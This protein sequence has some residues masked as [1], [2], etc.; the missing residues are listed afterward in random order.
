[1][2][3]SDWS[4]LVSATT[5]PGGALTTPTDLRLISV[6]PF[7][8]RIAWEDRSEGETFFE[9]E[10]SQS[11]VFT[12][13]TITFMVVSG[14]ATAGGS[15]ATLPSPDLLPGEDLFRRARAAACSPPAIC[16]PMAQTVHTPAKALAWVV[17]RRKP[18]TLIDPGLEPGL[19]YHYRVRALNPTDTSGWSNYLTVHTPLFT[20]DRL[21][22]S[23]EILPQDDIYPNFPQMTT[24]YQKS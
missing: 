1:M 20:D 15:G 7:Q 5:N 19:V 16:I 8:A 17:T 24:P 12:P 3:F 11:P 18:A 4:D 13:P 22:P 14:S 21:W 23:P 2:P 10:R 6:A 9:V